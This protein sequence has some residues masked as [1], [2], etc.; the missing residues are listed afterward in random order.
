MNHCVPCPLAPSETSTLL[1]PCPQVIVGNRRRMRAVIRYF[2]PTAFGQGDFVGMELEHPDGK[3]NG[4]VSGVPYFPCAP[5]C[6]LFV[7]SHILRPEDAGPGG[8][9]TAGTPDGSNST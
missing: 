2:G 1:R 4:T 3:N 5:G 7:Q 6:G 8:V 9:P